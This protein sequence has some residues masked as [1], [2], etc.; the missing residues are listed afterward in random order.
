MIFALKEDLIL[1]KY[2]KYIRSINLPSSYRKFIYAAEHNSNEIF[3]VDSRREGK[4]PLKS[5]LFR[6]HSWAQEMLSRTLDVS[7]SLDLIDQYSSVYIVY[8]YYDVV[9]L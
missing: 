5:S 7:S 3:Q 2:I 9:T 8:P 4:S 6:G 1:W